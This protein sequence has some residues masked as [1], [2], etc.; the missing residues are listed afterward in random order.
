MDIA[1]ILAVVFGLLIGSFLNVVIYRIPLILENMWNR[2]AKLQLG[3]EVGEEPIFNLMVPP[4]RC[5]NC[6]S[7]VRLGRMCRLSVGSFCV[8]NAIPAK[9][10]SAFAIRW[11]N[12]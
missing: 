1:I 4:S 8:A 6:G 10:L 9:R 2:E 3:M 11:L 5:G 7:P 12:Y